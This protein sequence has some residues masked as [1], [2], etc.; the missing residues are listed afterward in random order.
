MPCHFERFVEGGV[1]GAGEPEAIGDGGEHREHGEG[2]RSAHHVQVVDAAAVF[3]QPQ[4]LGEE[5]EV[6]QTPLGG[7][8]QVDERVELDLAARLRVGPHRGV[9][10]SWEVCAQVDRLAML[11]FSDSSSAPRVRGAH[12]VSPL[13]ISSCERSRSACRCITDVTPARRRRRFGLS[14]ASGR[15]PHQDRHPRPQP[16]I[17]RQRSGIERRRNGYPV[18]VT[19]LSRRSWFTRLALLERVGAALT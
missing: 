3:A 2:V 8:G 7:S 17:A 9:V 5:E 11:A 12:S 13:A 1:D 4:P 19:P 10:D 14:P 6:E 16:R 15:C 18:D